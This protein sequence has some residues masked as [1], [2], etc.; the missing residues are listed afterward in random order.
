MK[1]KSYTSQVVG[2]SD[3]VPVTPGPLELPGG[4]CKGL[5]FN[6]AGT[7][8]I[9]TAMNETRTG[10]PV[11]PGLLPIRVK[12]VTAATPLSVWAIY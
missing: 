3:I 11:L 2:G 10:V 1:G 12:R 4:I 5:W 7:V 9:V 6:E 8:D